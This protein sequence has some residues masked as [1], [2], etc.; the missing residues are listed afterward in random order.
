MAFSKSKE[1][2]MSKYSVA[3]SD[4]SVEGFFQSLRLVS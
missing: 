3:E 1:V 2:N 4:L